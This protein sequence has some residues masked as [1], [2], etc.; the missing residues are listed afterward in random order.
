MEGSVSAKGS[1]L[2]KASWLVRIGR[3]WSL[4]PKQGAVPVERPGR[5]RLS[6]VSQTWNCP[7]TLVSQNQRSWDL[8][9]EQQSRKS[10]VWLHKVFE[11]SEGS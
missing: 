8:I 3:K 5:V 11:A 2:S 10:R 6:A 7:G 9:I 1:E 4:N